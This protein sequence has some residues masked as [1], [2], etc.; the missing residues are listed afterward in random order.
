MEKHFALLHLIAF[1]IAITFYFIWYG[2]TVDYFFST[3]YEKLD[4]I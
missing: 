4:Q 1:S 2:K 3:I